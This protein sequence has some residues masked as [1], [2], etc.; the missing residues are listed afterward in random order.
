[1]WAGFFEF[2]VFLYSFS[3]GQRS[4]CVYDDDTD[5]LVFVID[6]G[7]PR[8]PSQGEVQEVSDRVQKWTGRQF[9]AACFPNYGFGFSREWVLMALDR[10]RSNC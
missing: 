2:P 4:L 7:A 3:D 10:N 9:K 6:Y 1:M 5:V 8:L